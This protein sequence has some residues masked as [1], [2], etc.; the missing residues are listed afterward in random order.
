ME[1]FSSGQDSIN[2]AVVVIVSVVKFMHLFSFEYMKQ[3]GP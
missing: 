2:C 1:M 3:N